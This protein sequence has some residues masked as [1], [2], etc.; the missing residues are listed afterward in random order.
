MSEAGQTPNNPAGTAG[1]TQ[2]PPRLSIQSQYI[3]DLSFENPNPL[4]QVANPS[5]RPEIQIKVDV[6]PR[7]LSEDRF[8]VELDINAEAKVEMAPAGNADS[9]VETEAQKE[10]VFVAELTYGGVFLIANVPQDAMQPLLHIECPRLIFPFARRIIADTT[11]DGGF[12]P[13]MVDP[14]D[15]A[16][17]YR[18]RLQAAQQQ[19][20]AAQQGEGSGGTA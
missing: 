5:A 11:R 12:P 1:Q 6:R 3:K 20:Q 16:G 10:T 9:P 2:A 8:E 14:I 4:R 7:Q 19:A 18:R 17:L 13:L 15:F